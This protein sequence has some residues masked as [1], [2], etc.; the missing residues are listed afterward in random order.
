[1]FF[2][3][4]S[5]ERYDFSDHKVEYTL[6]H[7]SSDELFE[8]ELINVSERGLCIMS[9]QPLAVGQ[10]IT[11]KDFMGFSSRTA[12]VIWIAED[13]EKSRFDASEQGLFKIGLEFSE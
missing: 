2:D 4:R 8:A 11:L 6:G 1:M 3:N 9:P 5:N 10:E 13:E 12:L 7:F